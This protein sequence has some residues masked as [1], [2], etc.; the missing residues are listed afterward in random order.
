MPISLRT[1]YTFGALAGLSL[2][3]SLAGCAADDSTASTDTGSGADD[4]SSS[5]APAESSTGSDTSTDA[6]TDSGSDDGTD[7]EAGSYAD[8]TYSA[9][10]EYTSPGGSESI[11]VELT[12][13]GDTVTAVTVTPNATSGNSV[14]Y[15]SDFAEGIADVVVGENIDDLDVDRVAGSSLT[16]GGFNEAVETIKAEAAA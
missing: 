1:R 12:L 15:Q 9:E 16:S 11:S 13:E 4:S 2:I 8:G 6:G 7:T 3:G 14:R 10:G 5:S